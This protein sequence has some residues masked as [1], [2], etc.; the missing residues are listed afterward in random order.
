LEYRERE[1]K[2]AMPGA[3]VTEE[4]ENKLTDALNQTRKSYGA[5]HGGS[6]HSR[7]IEEGECLKRSSA[8]SAL[9]ERD[10][11]NSI[12]FETK[13]SPEETNNEKVVV[14]GA[15]TEE[16]ASKPMHERKD[17]AYDHGG[18]PSGN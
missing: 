2:T 8:S 5:D 6:G 13:K 7:D 12:T 10:A 17:E 11:S 18:R 16:W 14:N 4:L 3:C 15:T 9:S 1:Q